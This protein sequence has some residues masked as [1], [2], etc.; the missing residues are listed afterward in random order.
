[1]ILPWVS[2]LAYDAVCSER[3]RLR[4][5]LDS[6]L[7]HVKRTDRLEHGVSEVPRPPRPPLE[8]MP[9]SL[10]EKLDGW[11]NASI[12]REERNQCFRRHAQGVSWAQIEQEVDARINLPQTQYATPETP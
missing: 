4:L 10:R 5:Q 2:R 1:M 8:P 9:H 6:L 7:D 11:S 3:D 12:R